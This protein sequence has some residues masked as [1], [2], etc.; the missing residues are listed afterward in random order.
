MTQEPPPPPPGITRAETI[1]V[2]SGVQRASMQW[3]RMGGRNYTRSSSTERSPPMLRRRSSLLSDFSLDEATTSLRSSTDNLLLPRANK[4]RSR[5]EHTTHEEPSHWHSAPLAFGL[6]P[7]VGGLLFK[8]GSAF[9]TDILLLGLAAIFLN[10]F[11]RLP[12][13]WYYSAQAVQYL[14]PPPIAPPS[15]TIIEEE[16]DE[17]ESLDQSGEPKAKKP[18]KEQPPRTDDQSNHAAQ[19]ASQELRKRELLALGACF[20]GPLLGAYLLHTIRGQLSRPSEGLVSNYNL[21]IFLL[22]SELRPC[23]HLIKM[24]QTQTLHLQ[25]IVQSHGDTS[26][27]PSSSE[28]LLSRITSLELQ[29]AGTPGDHESKGSQPEWNATDIADDVYSNIQPQLDALTRAVRRYEKRATTQTIQTEAR[30]QD[31][32]LRLR[33]AISLAAAAAESGQRPGLVTGVV[34]GVASAIM[35]PIHVLRSI[36]MYPLQMLNVSV[37]YLFDRI[38]GRQ[39]DQMKGGKRKGEV[40]G[41]GSHRVMTRQSK[42]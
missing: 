18:P 37:S 30:L 26:L 10:W 11:V 4:T 17:I 16:D 5:I 24:I 42:R 7:A 9:V 32:E 19:A 20:S 33:D 21:T 22:V 39:Q 41:I 36:F 40:P 29:A 35:M 27:P 15:D 31:L 2:S 28:D 6:L 34:H 3:Q 13:H 12:W 14:E 38:S 1:A 23:S 8:N 25:R